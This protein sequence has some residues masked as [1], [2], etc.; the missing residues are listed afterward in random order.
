MPRHWKIL[1]RHL[2]WPHP[3]KRIKRTLALLNQKLEAEWKTGSKAA[4]L[5]AFQTAQI[6][7]DPTR[8]T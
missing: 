3:V 2:V 6:M 8:F 4:R 5:Q 7:L 1:L